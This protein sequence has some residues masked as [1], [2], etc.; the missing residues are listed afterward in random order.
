MIE[1][2]EPR[3]LEEAIKKLNNCCEQSKCRF[4]TKKYWRGN[5]N[6]KGKW[7]KKRTRPKDI[8]NKENLVSPKKFNASERGQ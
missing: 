7:D 3:S 1:F 5:A 4:E 2:D 6:N 8:G